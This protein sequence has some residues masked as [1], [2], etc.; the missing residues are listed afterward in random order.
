V[1]RL[2]TIEISSIKVQHRIR[3]E[4]GDVAVLM[5]SMRRHGLFNPL[6]VTPDYV[7]IAGRRRLEAARRLG[8]RTIQCRVV[9]TKEAQDVLEIEIEEN[10]ARKDFSSDE[11]ADA[12]VRLDR[13]KNPSF[14]RRIVMWVRGIWQR[15]RKALGAR[16]GG[17]MR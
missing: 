10:T 14:W 16:R 15:V 8:W 12:L 2:E 11:L 17:S 13:L 5:D 7:L 1:N 4:L 6:V 9:S 3:K